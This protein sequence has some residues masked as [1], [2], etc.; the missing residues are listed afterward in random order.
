MRPRS[1]KMRE[2]LNLAARRIV[3]G[4]SIKTQTP[5]KYASNLRRYGHFTV[6]PSDHRTSRRARTRVAQTRL[7]FPHEAT[8]NPKIT[9]EWRQHS[10]TLRWT[11]AMDFKETRR[12]MMRYVRSHC[13]G[14]ECVICL[15]SSYS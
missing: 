9:V 5:P 6:A 4:L 2:H 14:L 1:R 13:L 10:S 12:W 11:A 15:T 7:P 8:R 3:I